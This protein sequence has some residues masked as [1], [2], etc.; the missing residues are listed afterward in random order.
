VRIDLIPG[1]KRL[2]HLTLPKNAKFWFAFVNQNGVWPWREG[3]QILIPLEQ[4]TRNDTVIPV[5]LFYSSQVGGADPDELDLKLLAPKFD[6][7]LE[8]ITWNIFLN[9]KWK[10]TKWSGSLQKQEERI[11]SHTSSVDVQSYLQGEASHQREKTKAAEQMLALGNNALAQGNPREARRAFESAYGLSQHDNAFNEDAR[12]QLHNLKLQQALVGLNV[13][14]NTITGVP[15]P[16]A[17]KLRGAGGVPNKDAN[18]TQQDAK[19]QMGRNTA[20]DN[21]AFIKLAERLIQQQDAAV[22]NPAAIQ[23]TV[24]EQGR[25][26][27]FSRTVAVDNWA[28]LQIGLEAKAA[29]TAGGFKR[30]LILIATALLLGTL[31][32][33]AGAFRSKPTTV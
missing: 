30:F 32:K 23:A 14:N 11:V 6:L 15:D 25:L 17:G 19:D 27:T 16:L 8:N 13:R 26:I 29:K 10:V 21:A 31:A 7:P 33:F 5:S 3:E 2:L 1:D 9:E 4:Q 20:D 28:D 18:Y 22:S 24:P 12:V